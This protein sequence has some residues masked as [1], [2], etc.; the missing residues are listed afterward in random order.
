MKNF[1]ARSCAWMTLLTVCLAAA[2]ALFAAGTAVD[3][4]AIDALVARE[5]SARGLVGISLAIAR[6]G[7]IV[8][9]RGYGTRSIADKAPAA[10]DTMFAIGSVT[11]QF[12]CAC[13]L[14]LAEDGKLAVTDKVAKYYPKLTRAADI[15]LLDLMNHVSGYPDYYP[16]DFV[17]LRMMKPIA[18]DEVIRLYGTGKLDF[19]PGTRY[20]YSNTGYDLLGRV[21]EKVSGE[22]F[23]TFLSGRILKPLGLSRTVYEPATDGT[24]FA[25]GYTTFA[26]GAPEPAVPEAKSWVAAAGAI[27]STA[28]DLARWDLALM[29]GKVLKPESLK[30]MTTPRTLADGRSTGYG[31]GLSVGERSGKTILSHNGA[32]AGF[33]AYNTMVPDGKTAVVLISNFDVSGDVAA[34]YREIL[35]PLLPPATPP[36]AAQAKPSPVVP[37][38]KGVPVIAGPPAPEQSKTLFLSL[39]SGAVD[40]SKL[41]PDFSWFLTEA[42]IRGASERL[43]TYG[44]PTGAALESINERGG[45]EVTS[46]RLRFGGKSL[47]SLMYRTPDGMIQQ[48]FLYKD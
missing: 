31:C 47:R 2:P 39:Q 15:T 45:M 28:G 29:S 5:I 35:I 21:V 34:L 33:L 23:G 17:D 7:V 36:A 37:Q 26:L 40:R 46:V 4:K 19:E 27:Y 10:G 41:S 9:D 12:T 43:K 25:R 8:L 11:K 38:P 3:T 14:L 22:P 20:S 18:V 24:G 13:I 48:Y 42:K 16:L 44:E 6:D 1:S 30:L 32:V